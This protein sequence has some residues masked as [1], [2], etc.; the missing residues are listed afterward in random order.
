MVRK[1]LAALAITAV[2]LTP[3][4]AESQA[5]ST[6]DKEAIEQIVRNYILENPEIIEEAIIKLNENQQAEAQNAQRDAVIANKDKLYNNDSD[7]YIGSADA[8]ITVVEFFDYRCGY[9]KR[10]TDWIQ[11]L[12]EKY[13]GDV[14]VV[15]KELPILSPESEQAA[16]AALAAG[17]QDKYS[18]MH[19]ALME[20]PSNSGF[21][22]ADID[23][24]AKSVG[25]DV[26][27]MR[28]DMRSTDIQK[29]L[30]EMKGLAREL[31]VTGT[32]AFFI[33]D[34]PVPGGA[35]QDALN[36]LIEIELAS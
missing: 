7:Y 29:Q 10:S 31:N 35:N 30:A 18:D 34:R 4:C 8:K 20:L 26:T 23:K 2:A 33:G 1:T 15:F 25:V 22:T 24:V 36:A 19:R 14:R 17:K 11:A 13:D 16:L 27:K 32:P 21:K 28:A 6:A 5:T 3:A 12:P 9:C